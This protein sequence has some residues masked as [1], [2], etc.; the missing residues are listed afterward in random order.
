MAKK[1]KQDT[2]PQL[3]YFLKYRHWKDAIRLLEY[4]LELK[5]TNRHFNT[6]S[7]FYYERLGEQVKHV[8]TKSYFK[9]RVANNLFYG[10]EDE[11]AILPYPVPKSNLG[12]R[13]YKFLTYPMRITY[14]AVGVYLLQVAQ[15]ILDYHRRQQHVF[16]QYGGHI[17][18][19][20]ASG[21]LNLRYD[22][23]WYKPHYKAF[24]SRVRR[25]L[26]GDVDKRAIIHVDVQNFYDEIAI[27]KLMQLLKAFV[28]PSVQQ[29][30]RFD[31]V[32]QSQIAS[33][34]SFL[35]NGKSGIPQADNDIVSSLIGHLYLAF[36]DIIIDQLLRSGEQLLQAYDIIRFAD[37][38]YVSI[39][40]KD[41][42]SLATMESFLGELAS[43][44]ADSLYVSLGLRLNTK[45]RL[46]WLRDPRDIEDFKRNLKRVSPGY[47]IPD[48][49]KEDP[50]KKIGRILDQLEK[51]KRS[52]IDP[53]FS[54]RRDLDEEVLKDIYDKV[55]DQLFSK[56]SNIRRLKLLFE[57][58][59]FDLVNAQPR[60]I[61]IILLRDTSARE[62]FEQFLLA[63]ENLTTRD[64]SLIVTFLCQTNFE[65]NEV[66]GVLRKSGQMQPI[67]K[68]F[69]K[70]DPSSQSPGYFGMS[71]E[72]VLRLSDKPRVIDQIKLRVIAE[73]KGD[74]S[75]AL[76][77]LLNELQA[78]CQEF[79]GRNIAER[80]YD[81][82]RV[83]EFLDSRGTSYE[84]R[85]KIR[86]LFDRRNKNPVS[87]ADSLAWPVDE[88]EYNEYHRFVGNSL[89]MLLQ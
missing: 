47:E 17:R 38:M 10:L 41:D 31:S 83:I 22:S 27:P 84:T 1:N 3:G 72:K 7:M 40:F 81:A 26:K 55:V 61:M 44:I 51:L 49:D 65:S 46:Y 78:A 56:D 66:L 16:S 39:T 19:D 15:D 32:T 37:D 42:V 63:K 80:D 8:G 70:N 82:N 12:L 89:S 43:K 71:A 35:A 11:F 28:K 58:F 33:F 50:N 69:E 77:H 85:L 48:D 86:N 59:N 79:D 21:K 4:Q 52:S 88:T 87:H 68:V 14:Y 73:R 25:E 53:T 57:G 6:I 74:F 60:E 29:H 36:G 75:V 24:R 67:V 20:E 62:R 54:Q 13:N 2:T 64:V 30:T 18:L 34:F 9:K 5:K 76:N 45:T 23:V